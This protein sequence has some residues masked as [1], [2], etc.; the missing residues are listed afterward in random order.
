MSSVSQ[1][2][3]PAGGIPMT[4][5]KVTSVD[6]KTVTN[7]TGVW[8]SE[9]ATSLSWRNDYAYWVR[10]VD[11][12]GLQ[13]DSEPVDITP[14]KVSASAPGTPTSQWNQAECA[15]DLSWKVTDAE[16]AG[17]VLEREIV[18]A[19]RQSGP[20]PTLANTSLTG[21]D[22]YVQISGITTATM[23][24]YSD[25]T[26][27][28]DNNYVY[29]V[30]T[31]DKAGNVSV[32]AVVPTSVTVPDTCTAGT[33]ARHV[34]NSPP[35]DAET[36]AVATPS[37]PANNA[38]KPADE[39]TVPAT[40][41]DGSKPAGTQSGSSQSTSTPSAPSTTAPKPLDDIEI[42]ATKPK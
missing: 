25:Y 28:P 21:S 42:P 22:S 27:F 20:I 34:K 15:V 17:F 5:T 36:P 12:D 38:P 23:S 19:P 31:V 29:R 41:P 6:A 30:R 13:S 10:T 11:Q 26:V 40:R 35:A 8:L 16:T 1:L 37:V 2:Q 9:A 39:I 3:N 32:P 18:S 33:T 4:A 7:G 14:L 24:Q